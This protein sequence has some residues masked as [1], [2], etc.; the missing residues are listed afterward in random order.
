MHALQRIINQMEY[1]PIKRRIEN[2]AY[3]WTLFHER[4][5]SIA[6]VKAALLPAASPDTTKDGAIPEEP[7]SQEEDGALDGADDGGDV[8]ARRPDR[9]EPAALDWRASKSGAPG[10]RG[11]R[12]RVRGAEAWRAR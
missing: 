9:D 3:F 4:R 11:N 6:T 12:A 10:G 5:R 7:Q 1:R 2:G 8:V